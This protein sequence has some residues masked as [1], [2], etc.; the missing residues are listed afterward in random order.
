MIILTGCM[1]DQKNIVRN[2]MLKGTWESSSAT[3]ILIFSED[4]LSISSIYSPMQRYPY[5][6]SNNKI[7]VGGV[8]DGVDTF[9]ILSFK[10]DSLLLDVGTP[11]GYSIFTYVK[12]QGHHISNI[13]QDSILKFIV[14]DSLRLIYPSAQIYQKIY[15]SK[16]GNYYVE[17]DSGTW[18]VIRFEGNLF[19]VLFNDI[20]R[21][22]VSKFIDYYSSSIYLD[23]YD[24]VQ[25]AHDTIQ[26]KK[27]FKK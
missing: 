25:Y 19:L 11:K 26:L 18:E 17:G 27:A 23:V 10:G 1:T 20:G 4:S 8:N 7:I 15:F 24:T 6:L 22:S 2:E 5:L 12:K 16:N 14:G 13:H 21:I 9:S 3:S